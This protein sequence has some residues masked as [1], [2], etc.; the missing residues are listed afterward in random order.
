MEDLY[1]AF[2]KYGHGSGFIP[3]VDSSEDGSPV[4]ARALLEA[5]DE[6]KLLAQAVSPMASRTHSEEVTDDLFA[7]AEAMGGMEPWTDH[8][9]EQ[10][11]HP[12]HTGKP[13]PASK[14]RSA[15]GREAT[16]TEASERRRVAKPSQRMA[17]RPGLTRQERSR[18]VEAE[19]FSS[20]SFSPAINRNSSQMVKGMSRSQRQAFRMAPLRHHEPK[21]SIAGSYCPASLAC[22]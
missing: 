12:L 8:D 9:D 10:L 11:E 4:A 19:H 6:Q 5:L 2:E 20:T 16:A 15:R 22:P 21:P 3:L 17:A 18:R 13:S 7:V 14:L 1:S